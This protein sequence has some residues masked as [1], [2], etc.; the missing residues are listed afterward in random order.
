[1]TKG[2]PKGRPMDTPSKPHATPKAKESRPR[3]FTS[4]FHASA[5]LTLPEDAAAMV[6]LLAPRAAGIGFDALVRQVE[7]WADFE[8]Q[9]TMNDPAACAWLQGMVRGFRREGGIAHHVARLI[10][11]LVGEGIVFTEQRAWDGETMIRLAPVETWPERHFLTGL[12]LRW[13][14]TE[15][16]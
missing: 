14:E 13:E 6:G 8:I 15:T 1:M 16:T 12:G 10:A 3:K 7:S 5:R 4:W 9:P 2:T 11:T